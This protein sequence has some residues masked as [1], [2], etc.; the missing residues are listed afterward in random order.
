VRLLLDEVYPPVLAE[1]LRRAGFEAHTVAELGHAGRSDPDVFMAA[2]ADGLMV[3]TEN[4]ADFARISAEH[5]T[6]GQHHPGVL[7]ALSSRFS[8]RPAGV[9]AIVA[10]IRASSGE[11]LDDRVI[12]LRRV[13]HDS[14]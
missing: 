2:V 3:L 6:A 5:L 12:Y 1:A 7:V 4:A 10:S 8:R 11:I 14:S 13:Q 9:A